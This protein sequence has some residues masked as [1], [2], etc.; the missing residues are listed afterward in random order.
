MTPTFAQTVTGFARRWRQ[1]FGRS[2]PLSSR[3]EHIRG[4]KG[5]DAAC[6]FLRQRGYKILYRNF[7]HRAGGEIDVV[8]RDGETLVFVEVKTRANEDLRRPHE[9]I[10]TF[11]KRRI[12]RGALAWMRM[13]D[14]PDVAFRFDVVEV[15]PAP[16]GCLECEL[17]QNAFELP[18]GCMY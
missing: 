15:V 8:C 3:P 13:L 14:N 5:E 18:A 6:R 7:K 11:Q 17:V 12:S 9:D 2:K 16:N 1:R 4:R 10:K